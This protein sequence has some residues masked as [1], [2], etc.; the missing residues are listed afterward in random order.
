VLLAVW[1]GATTLLAL[2][3]R[4][5]HAGAPLAQ[6]LARIPRAEWGMLVAHFGIGVFIFGVTMVKTWEAEQ[7]VRMEAGDTAQLGGYSFKLQ[8]FAEYTGPNY[9]GL[10]ATIEV[11]RDGRHVDTMYPEK[12]LYKAQGMPMTEAAIDAGF[13]RDVYVSLGE[14]VSE[15]AWAV[16]LQVKPFINWIWGGTLLMALGGL[17]AATDRRYRLARKSSEEAAAAGAVPAGSSA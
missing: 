16:R 9:V 12:R 10:R 14:A 2:R 6:R 5:R 11:S 13:T 15:T 1:V 17:L 3:E 8:D 4:V 7:D